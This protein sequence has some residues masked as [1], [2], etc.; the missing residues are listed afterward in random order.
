[1]HRYFPEWAD[2]PLGPDTQHESDRNS[3]LAGGYADEF[4]Y[5]TSRD[6]P[7]A[8]APLD[9]DP[10]GCRLW[11]EQIGALHPGYPECPKPLDRDGRREASREVSV[12]HS[13]RPEPHATMAFR[14]I[15][16]GARVRDPLSYAVLR[17]KA[18]SYFAERLI[19]SRHLNDVM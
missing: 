5:G 6:S 11:G 12:I 1:M 4:G 13:S 8:I 16:V 14:I 19:R 10:E 17:L 7:P 3:Y 18:V 15:R 9:G 2:R